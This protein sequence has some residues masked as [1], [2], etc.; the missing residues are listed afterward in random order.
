GVADDRRTFWSTRCRQDDIRAGHGG[1]LAGTRLCRGPQSQSPAG[2]IFVPRH[3]VQVR[4]PS[5]AR[6]AD[7]K[8]RGTSVRQDAV[9]GP[10]PLRGFARRQSS[11]HSGQGHAAFGFSLAAQTD[12]ISYAPVANLGAG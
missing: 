5:S 3:A 6:L 10:S 12:P 1:P 11:T 7:D 2:R 8:P 4:P 9:D